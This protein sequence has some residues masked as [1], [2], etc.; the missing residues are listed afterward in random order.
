M[1]LDVLVHIDSQS[2][3]GRI[4][5]SIVSRD[6]VSPEEAVLRLLKQLVDQRN[7]GDQM[8]GAFS[9]PDSTLR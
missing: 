6:N 7:P 4:V 2:P 8:W 9:S 5:E 3:E 1:T